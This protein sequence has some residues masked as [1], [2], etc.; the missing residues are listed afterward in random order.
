[1][2]EDNARIQALEARI[3]ELEAE[4]NA[5]KNPMWP[6]AAPGCGALFYYRDAEGRPYILF[7][8]RGHAHGSGLG[9][10]GGGFVAVK[11]AQIYRW[12]EAPL[13]HEEECYRELCEEFRDPGQDENE[14]DT[15]ADVVAKATAFTDLVPYDAFHRKAH[16]L[17]GFVVQTTDANKYHD[18]NFFGYEVGEDVAKAIMALPSN[19]ERP[20]TVALLA[21]DGLMDDIVP[22]L[23]HAHEA[24]PIA[25]LHGILNSV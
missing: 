25:K 19:D 9:I 21:A 3:R 2:P 18:C 23:F 12:D 17:A 20:E 10:T 22:K 16:R 8:Q 11:K 15:F 13:S 14:D 5:L 7:S 1:M 24:V 4:N 6:K